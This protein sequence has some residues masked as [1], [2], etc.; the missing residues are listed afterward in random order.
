MVKVSISEIVNNSI[1]DSSIVNFKTVMKRSSAIKIRQEG[2]FSRIIN[3]NFLAENLCRI[4][5]ISHRFKELLK[6]LIVI[7]MVQNRLMCRQHSNR[8]FFYE[9]LRKIFHHYV[10]AFHFF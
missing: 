9:V 7:K 1:S 3:F 6:L 8:K 2:N 4:F 5:M 10:F